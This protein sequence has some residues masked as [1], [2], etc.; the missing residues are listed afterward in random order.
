MMPLRF[1]HLIF[2]CGAF[3]LVLVTLLLLTLDSRHLGLNHIGRQHGHSHSMQS[4]SIQ[5]MQSDPTQ[6]PSPICTSYPTTE[7]LAAD[8]RR[9]EAIEQDLASLAKDVELVDFDLDEPARAYYKPETCRDRLLDYLCDEMMTLIKRKETMDIVPKDKLL[10]WTAD[11]ADSCSSNTTRVALIALLSDASFK[12]SNS[13]DTFAATVSLLDDDHFMFF[14]HVDK[15]SSAEFKKDVAD[16]VS[17]YPRRI[18]LAQHSYAVNWGGSRM[19]IATI[20]TMIQAQREFCPDFVINLSETHLATMS[21]SRMLRWLEGHRNINYLHQLRPVKRDEWE[22]KK[23]YFYMSDCEAAM[24]PVRI[25]VSGRLPPPAAN[26]SS[27]LGDPYHILT[28]ALNSTW[29]LERAKELSGISDLTPWKGSQWFVLSKAFLDWFL[30]SDVPRQIL[31]FFEWWEVPDEKYFATCLAFS[32]FNQ[33]VNRMHPA[34]YVASRKNGRVAI[35]ADVEAA[36]RDQ[37]LFV[38]KVT[39]MT[40]LKKAEALIR[41]TSS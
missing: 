23:S 40:L 21:A 33:T 2:V 19:V 20:S 17:L 36:M 28:T 22:G 29:R 7:L 27:P 38:R 32:P 24:K 31:S 35:M 3:A 37:S 9:L 25:H 15:R 39:N 18:I 4:H 41:M 5:S 14:A 13:L 30:T 34:H 12:G 8:R 11:S 16:L 1:C 26:S 10:N 6:K